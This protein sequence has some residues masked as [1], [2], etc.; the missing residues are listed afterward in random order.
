MSICLV[1]SFLLLETQT[2]FVVCHSNSDLKEERSEHGFFQSKMS[3][4]INGLWNKRRIQS[5]ITL[6]FNNSCLLFYQEKKKREKKKAA[7]LYFRLKRTYFSPKKQT[8]KLLAFNFSPLL[9]LNE[10]SITCVSII[11]ATNLLC[12]YKLQKLLSSIS[13][14]GKNACYLANWRV[15]SDLLLSSDS[16]PFSSDF[17]LN[18]TFIE[19]SPKTLHCITRLFLSLHYNRIALGD[20][21]FI[22]LELNLLCKSE[23]L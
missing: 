16:P 12:S 21:M 14:K 20:N 4:L 8:P 5:I 1:F 7:I 18:D 10:K 19:R 17:K 6:C 13:L 23:K 3:V 22:T 11:L 15:K 2:L 9:L